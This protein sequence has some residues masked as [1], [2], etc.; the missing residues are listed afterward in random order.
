VAASNCK[1]GVISRALLADVVFDAEDAR[2]G[3]PK[4]TGGAQGT[5]VEF[6]EMGAAVLKGFTGGRMVAGVMRA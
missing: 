6:A 2:L 5:P 4:G 1:I 3:T